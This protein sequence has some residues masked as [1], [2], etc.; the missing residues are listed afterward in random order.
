MRH[1]LWIT[2]P[3]LSPVQIV[4]QVR[5]AASVGL[6]SA[7]LLQVLSFDALTALAVAG[8][9]VPGIGLGTA[10]VPTFPRHPL[11]L[12]SQALTTQAAIGNR[13]TLGIGLSHR[14]IIEGNFGIPFDRPARHMRE[15]LSVLA[16]ALRGETVDHQGETLAASATLTVAGATPPSLVVAALGPAM[17]R[18]AG[19][20]TDGTVTVFTG[21][22]TLA[23]HIVPGITRAAAAAGRAAPR[24]VVG[25]RVCVT[26]DAAARQA[27]LAAQHS[28]MGDTPPS[29]RAV[30]DREGAAGPAD[31]AIVGDESTVEREI[32]RYAD[33]GA[34][35]FLASPFGTGEE[36]A[37]TLELVAALGQPG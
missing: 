9:E 17:L 37:R 4:E 18:L 6:S 15:Y 14:S 13:L 1:G 19:E 22:N 28:A 7:W 24:V 31:V 2:D 27:E 11:A 16:P 25:V 36:Q 20:L 23:G 3:G 26:A 29:Y 35:E 34:T 5:A 12:A 8:R 32:R 33:A 30:L 10:V 21:P